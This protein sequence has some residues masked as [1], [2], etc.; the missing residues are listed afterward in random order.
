M[1]DL[2]TENVSVVKATANSL[3]HVISQEKNIDFLQEEEASEMNAVKLQ[4]LHQFREEKKDD[5]DFNDH[6]DYKHAQTRTQTQTQTLTEAKNITPTYASPFVHKKYT[7]LISLSTSTILFAT[8]E[9]FARAENLL[10]DTDPEFIPDLYCPQGKVMDGW[11]TRR[12]RV[13]G[14]DWCVVALGNKIKRKGVLNDFIDTDTGTGTDADAD[15]DVNVVNELYGIEIDTAHFTGNQTPRVSIQVANLSNPNLTEEEWKYT[16]MPG[17]ISR[18]ARGGGIQ[19]T[20]MTPSQ[21]A[22]ADAA[23]A[24]QPSCEWTTVLPMTELSPGY[25]ES[26]MHY[27]KMNE[28]IRD[29]VRGF[30]HVRVNY[31]PDGGVARLRLWGHQVKHTI[32]HAATST[33]TSTSTAM[34]VGANVAST[35]LP[36]AET[37]HHPELSSSANGGEGLTCSNKHYGV[38]SNLIRPTYG[39]DMGD[40]WET[41]RHPHRPPV[42]IKDPKTDLIDSPLMDWAILKL[43]MGGTDSTGV[44]RIILDTKH[45]KGNFPESVKIE[46]CDANQNQS[47]NGSSTSSSS[48]FPISDEEVCEFDESATATTTDSDSASRVAWFPL[49]H[50]CRMGPDQEHVF[51]IDSK[52]LVNT[53]RNVT[54]VRVSI[55]PDGGLSRVR[56]YGQPLEMVI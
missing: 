35:V 45:F 39:K 4:Q 16:W 27:F 17:A 26:R 24:S 11:E 50:R 10:K 41:A 53:D 42:L 12:R 5:D 44:S 49:L 25:E 14:H 46:A 6:H 51:D 3:P 21:V 48:S 22:A 55:F 54:H 15:A 13:A 43:G 29:K 38:P 31:F 2:S 40:G 34:G 20:G 8:D 1:K 47:Q 28:E 56:I 52:E 30:T 7:N 32:E 19:G 18:M 33:S 23:C 9:W 37:Y 36:S